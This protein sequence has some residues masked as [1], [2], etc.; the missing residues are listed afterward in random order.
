M[1]CSELIRLIEN[2]FGYA[3]ATDFSA[4]EETALFWYVSE[5]K[6]EPR[7]GRRH[8]EAGAACEMPLDVARRDDA[9]EAAS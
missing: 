8:E 4:A 6:L 3:L 5:E 9:G 7:L 2:N 1:A